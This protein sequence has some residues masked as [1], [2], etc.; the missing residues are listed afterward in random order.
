MKLN[1]FFSVVVVYVLKNCISMN[2]S[3]YN[4]ATI[5]IIVGEIL[6]V[7]GNT[8]KQCRDLLGSGVYDILTQA[9]SWVGD[10]DSYKR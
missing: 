1:E 4:I 9:N 6:V 7:I 3:V 5:L 8:D 2:Y 10:E